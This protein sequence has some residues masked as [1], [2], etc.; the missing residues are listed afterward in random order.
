MKI[1]TI[2][3]TIGFTPMVEIVKLNPNPDVRILAKIEGSN[4]TGSIKD[5]ISLAMIEH[6]EKTGQLTKGKTIIEAT[7]G[8]TGIG[9]AM[10]AAIKGYKAI[11]VMPESM[12]EERRKMIKT[13]GAELILVKPEMW[14]DGAVAMI[15]EMAAK[16]SKLVLLNQFDNEQNCLAHYRT[17]GREILKQVDGPIDYFIAGLGTGGTITGIARRLREKNP[18]VR[19]VGI[20]PYLGEKIEGLRSVKSGRVPKILEPCL[21][22]R[23]HKGSL[24]DIV[25]NIHEQDAYKTARRL[26]REEGTICGSQFAR[27]A[28]RAKYARKMEK[29]TIVTVFPDR[30]EKYLSTSM[31]MA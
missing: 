4:P 11:I 20:Q 24:I 10:V 18:D 2:L 13:F 29:G 3:D 6:A 17:T 16:D 9:L 19:V 26:A 5:R 15:K 27:A 31:F 23:D 28:S 25:I 7:S 1:G 30:G 12:S 21:P 8:N 22:C 14:R